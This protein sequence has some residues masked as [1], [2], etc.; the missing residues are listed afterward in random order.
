[1]PNYIT[2]SLPIFDLIQNCVM[3]DHRLV[4]VYQF[5][6]VNIGG[7]KR[8]IASVGHE[9]NTIKG[10]TYGSIRQSVAN[11]PLDS[12]ET[13]VYELYAT[14]FVINNV[15]AQKFRLVVKDTTEKK[16]K[17]KWIKYQ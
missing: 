5:T 2:Q 13:L 4:D 9:F 15:S 11:V 16:Y 3:T 1:L 7:K 10:Y 14:D 12:G 17:T 8:I 6:I